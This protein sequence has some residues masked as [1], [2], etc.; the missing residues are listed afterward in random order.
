MTED[1]NRLLTQVG[2]GTPMGR[3]MRR[4]WI[5]ALFS[6]QLSGPDCTPV[7]LKLLGE[8]LVAFRDTNGRIG[9]LDERC[10]HR[11][12]SLFFG[13]NE[14]SGLRCVYHGWKFDVDGNCIDMPSE[15]A[16]SNFMHKVKTTAYPTEEHGGVIWTHMGPPE[17]RPEFPDLEWTKVPASHRFA[18]RHEQECNW[19]QG[20]EGGFD[21]AHLAFLHKGSVEG[22]P[23][24]VPSRYEVIATD[25]GYVIGTGRNIPSG[26][27]EWS[28]NVMLTPFHKLIATVPHGAHVWVPIDD[29]NTMLYSVDYMANRP[30]NQDELALFREGLHTHT[31]NI[32]GTDRPVQNK[33]NDYLIDRQLQRSGRSF[34]GM[35]G[36]GI[37][38]CALQE[39]MGPVADRTIEHLGVSDTAIIKIRRLLLQALA[40]LAA[41]A[42]PPGLKAA[43]Y[44]VRSARFRLA[45]GRPF[46]AHVDEHIRTDQP[47]YAK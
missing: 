3:L 45:Q 22:G 5:P 15:P 40:D 20:L 30:L 43:S 42:E 11:T 27:T 9:L 13:R 25:F 23:T 41:G 38:D 37:Q 26:E 1:E 47:A 36:L 35:K 33:D 2:P 32:A 21:S 14:Q 28:A 16:S 17:Q 34:T 39:T 31:N 4:Y 12:V 6:H 46:Q 10:P 18:S 8:R 29:D 24:I 7:R 44:R 19:L